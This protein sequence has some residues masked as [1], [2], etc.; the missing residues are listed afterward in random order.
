MVS[1]NLGL[2][3]RPEYTHSILI[4]MTQLLVEFQEN[5]RGTSTGFNEDREAISREL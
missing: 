2:H 5:T 1:K 4:T 3:Y